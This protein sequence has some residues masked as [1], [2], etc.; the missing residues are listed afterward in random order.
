MNLDR[1]RDL[2][3]DL[4]GAAAAVVLV[5]A[6]YGL[7]LHK[8]LSDAMR[9]GAMQE[10][11]AQVNEQVTTLRSACSSQQKE[12]ENSRLRLATLAAS[13]RSP[14]GTDELLSRLDHLA[15]ECGLQLGGWQ[16]GGEEVH[17]Q[18]STHIY[19][20]QGRAAFPDLCKWLSLV[21]SGVPLLDITHFTIRGAG[22]RSI[23]D[24]CDFECTLRLYTGWDAAVTEVAQVTP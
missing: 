24:K 1:V 18:Y 3:I 17:D 12:T 13:L 21:E 16:P 4:Y 15:S 23:D 19:W 20:I 14:G 5:A 8:P 22:E 7:Y 11:Y 9:R 2:Q 10:R 6:G